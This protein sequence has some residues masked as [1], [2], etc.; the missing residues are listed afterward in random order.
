MLLPPDAIIE[1]SLVE[2]PNQAELHQ[3]MGRLSARNFSN[4][5]PFNQLFFAYAA[6]AGGK[7]LLGAVVALR[8]GIILA[9]L[10]LFF[11][12]RKLL[13]KLNKSPH[14]IFWYFLNPL[15]VIELTG[16]LHF[17]GIMLFF[18]GW[19]LYL[20]AVGSSLKA[21][22]A[23]GLSI[24]SKLIPLMFLPLI[25]RLT[26]WRKSLPFYLAVGLVLIVLTLPFYTPDF[27]ENYTQTVGLWFSNF[28]FNAGIYNAVK[29]FALQYDAKPW[30]LIKVYGKI[31]PVLV[32]I[33]VAVFT[34]F[35]KKRKLEVI[36]PAMLWILTAYLLLSPTVHPWYVIS[37]VF[38][39]IYTDYRF[40]LFWSAL[41]ILSYSAYGESGFREHLW[42]LFIEYF[43]VFGYMIYEIIRVE[44]EKLL[45]RKN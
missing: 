1:N 40:P 31:V 24:A 16:N 32:I 9:D 44:G 18:L 8:L 30:K 28:E 36:L 7:S 45:I 14:L 13:K 29:H 33:L 42:L 37:L 10:G 5:P 27:L 34:F 39:T 20:L 2:F 23:F 41:V 6:F 12:G 38:L 25:I 22:P 17:E 19:S 3:G 26:G 4:Y 21:A 35:G 11:L 15:I 43:I